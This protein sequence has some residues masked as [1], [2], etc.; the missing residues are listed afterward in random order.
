MIQL[1][2]KQINLISEA[3][4]KKGLSL[5]SLQEELT[6]HIACLIELEMEKGSTFQDSFRIIFEQLAPEALR[7][8]Q[9]ETIELLNKKDKKMNR[10]VL[11]PI[12]GLAAS[13]L[14]VLAFQLTQISPQKEYGEVATIPIP[15]ANNPQA[16]LVTNID[17]PSRMPLNQNLK[18]TSAFGQRFHPIFKQKKMHRGVDFKA[19]MGT[20][21]YATANGVVEKVQ[22]HNKYGKLI[23]L[24]HDDTFQTLYAQLSVFEV[25]VG[26]E[27][28]KGD[29]IGK[30]GNSGLSTAPHLH[31]EVLEKGKAVDPQQFF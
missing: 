21:V 31:Y 4:I 18:I 12:L 26:E 17:P 8:I 1:T 20:P 10:K 22:T 28:K 25:K 27:V 2:D 15:K 13:F 23:V 11:I 9:A 24:K 7:S 14:L 30:T 19:P 16:I 6:D 5:D 3:L 29:L